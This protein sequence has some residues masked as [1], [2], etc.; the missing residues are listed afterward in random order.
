MNRLPTYRLICYFISCLAVLFYH[1]EALAQVSPAGYDYPHNHLPWFT[2][3][4]ENFLIHYQKGSSESAVTASRIAEEIYNPVTSL[5]GYEPNKKISIVL[6]DREDYSNGAAY[7]FDDK[8]EIWIP[9]LDSPLRGTHSWLRNVITH[10]FTH[11]VQLQ[12]SMKR[13]KTIPAIYLQW[14]SYEDVRRP[15]VLYGFPDGIVTFPFATVAIPAWF[16]EG[17]AQYQREE[18]K[19]DFWD[20]HRDMLLRTAILSDTYLDFT[21]MGYFSSKNSL[22]RELA[23]NQGFGFVIFLTDRFGEDIFADIS[24][25]AAENGKN[26]FDKI[27]RIATGSPGSDLFDEWIEE[28]RQHYRREVSALDLT[29]SSIIEKNGFFNFYPQHSPGGEWFGYLTNRGRDYGRTTLVLRKNGDEITVDDT[30]S[31]GILEG[32]QNYLVTHGFSKSISLD[33]ISNRFSFSPDGDLL[34]YSRA[35]KNRYGESYQDVYIY[36]INQ[37]KKTKITLNA[38]IKDPAWHPSDSLI[39]A[40]QQ[41]GRSQNIVLITPENGDV[42]P[43]TN[44]SSGET[45]FAPVWH[46]DGNEIYFS[47]ASDGSRNIYLLSLKDNSISPVFEDQRTDYRDPWPDPS[48]D[49]LYY[50]SDRSGIFNI[51]RKKTG[52]GEVQQLTNVAGGAF[53]PHVKDDILYFAEYRHDGYKI[54]SRPVSVVPRSRTIEPYIPPRENISLPSSLSSQEQAVEIAPSTERFDEENPSAEQIA[55]RVVTEAASDERNWQPYIET[56]TGFSVFPV[57]RFDNYSK[58]NG[59]NEKLLRA[60]QIGL[61]GENLWRDLK[62]GLYFST[63]D[64]TENISIFGGALV[65]FGSTPADGIGDFFSPSRLNDLDRDMFLIFDHR[66]LPFIKRSWSPTV[67]IEFFNMKRNVANGLSIEEFSCTSCLPETRFTDIR[68][69]IWEA[70]LFLRSKLNRWS[71][72]ELGATYSPYNVSTDG[73]FSEEFQEFIPGSTSEYFKG[74]TYSASYITELT[75]FSR[76]SDIA[77]VGLK[78][79]LTYQF[80]PARLLDEFEINDGLLSPVYAREFNHSVELR[81]RYGFPVAANSTG[82]MTLRTFTYFNDPDDT[83]YLDYIGGLIGMQSYPYFAIGGETTAFAR[84]SFITPVFKKINRQAGLF[85]FDKIFA[86]LFFEAGNGWKSSLDIGNQIKTGAGAELRFAFNSYYLFPLKFFINSTYGFN[87]FSMELSDDFITTSGENRVEYGREFL[88]R[89]GL[90]FDFDLL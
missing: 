70:S 57:V 72:L 20:S 80:Q 9:A 47:A 37:E 49:Y 6:R 75:E 10:E 77:P 25:A 22:Q 24:R 38:R 28:R 29:D 89:F 42:K 90:T 46:P 81:A 59:R 85:T 19:Y 79:N 50:S 35:K 36:Q 65:G 33:F 26:D 84:A 66:G 21:E 27:I 87:R 69:N 18:L 54:S 67:S 48:G 63:R 68:Y 88:F 30:G 15:D 32:E 12:S 86:H 60:G 13:T 14:L 52:T 58:L 31:A 62:T 34:T 45:V 39:A 7:F 5:Y 4:G 82:M 1:S 78:G 43:L 64:V 11:I 17:A 55:F 41:Q 56:I 71:L 23:Y 61:L 2:I 44:F 83:F 3:E 40:V 73:F 8:I 76:H 16:A 51:Y 53:M 74:T